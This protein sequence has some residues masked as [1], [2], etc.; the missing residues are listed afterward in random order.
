VNL[1][2]LIGRSCELEL[3]W[4]KKGTYTVI[5][6]SRPAPMAPA[7][8]IV[9]KPAPQLQPQPQPSMVQEQP[10]QSELSTNLHAVMNRLR[11]KKE[12]F[13]TG[14]AATTPEVSS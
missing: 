5:T 14:T 6:N 1:Y 11:E 7:P 8:R 12:S 3:G 13:T 10:E 4:N 2:D 9:T